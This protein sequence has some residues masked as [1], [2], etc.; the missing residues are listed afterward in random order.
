MT[1]GAGREPRGAL[2]TLARLHRRPAKLELAT[3]R[4]L[5]RGAVA[6][7]RRAA[8][9]QHTAGRERGDLG[10]QRLCGRA[11]L[12]PGHDA[13]RQPDTLGFLRVYGTAGEN[14]IER[15]RE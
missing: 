4:G 9:A 11:R 6:L 12:A 7:V 2:A 5:Q 3:Q 8:I 15:A 13:V 14:Q 10:R 1:A